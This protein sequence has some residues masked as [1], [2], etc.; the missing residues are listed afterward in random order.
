MIYIVSLLNKDK[1]FIELAR[2]DDCIEA[3]KFKWEYRTT[4]LKKGERVYVRKEII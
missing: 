4:K 1:Q 2:F 3:R